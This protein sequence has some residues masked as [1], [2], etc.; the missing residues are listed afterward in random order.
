M[1]LTI[2]KLER[3]SHYFDGSSGHTLADINFTIANS[4]GLQSALSS[5]SPYIGAVVKKCPKVSNYVK[6]SKSLK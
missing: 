6:M 5:Q 1:P 2:S 4:I 3:V